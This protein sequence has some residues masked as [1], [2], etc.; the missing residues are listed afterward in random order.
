[1]LGEGE[2][3]VLAGKRVEFFTIG[4]VA[5]A[6]GRRSGTLRA[7]EDR[8]IIPESGYVKRGK[9]PRGDRRLYTRAQAEG[10]IR[11]AKECGVMDANSR[12]P[13]HEFKAKVWALFNELKG[14][15]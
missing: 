8:Q 10:I 14:A 11:L 15:R 2:F 13:L 6:I 4:P 1:M 12:R 7:W 9:D 3:M 5:R